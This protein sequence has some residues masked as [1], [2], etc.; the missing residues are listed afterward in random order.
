MEMETPRSSE[1]RWSRVASSLPV[2]NVQDL[3]TCCEG[4]TEETLKRYIRLDTQDNEVLSEQS[5]EV[6]VID[7]GKLFNPDFAEEES[8]RL[9]FACEDWGF[10]QIV[11]HGIPD[12]VIASIRNDIEKFFQLPLEVKS[13]YAQ[14]PGDLQGYGQSFVVSESQTLDWSDMFVI[15]AHPPQARDMRYWPVQPHTFR[16]SIEEYSSELMKTAHSIVTVI[17][18]TLN[19]D[20]GLMN[21]KY[22][23]QYLRMNYYPPCMT[24][25]EKVLGFSPHSDGSFLTLLLE[26][27][28]VEGLQIKRY[29]AWIPVKPNPNALLVNVGDF[30]EIMSNGKYKS[31]E[32][33]VTI[34]TN[35][36]RLTLSAF[37]VPSLDG[38]VSPVTS[39]AEEKALYKTVGVEEYSKLYMS[40]KLDGKTALDHA[41][42]L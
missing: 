10:F 8:A 25:A 36:E 39:R 23:C 17:A 38:V 27:N 6:P 37:H 20:L 11:N 26:V 24:M 13:G 32:H 22:A 21:D 28:S 33:R 3:A 18:K 5:G 1:T 34:N 2:R 12:E 15:I 19:I 14:L 40:N 4:L 30:L 42:L 41:K 9:R 7:L 29:N 16:Q 31:I 35:K